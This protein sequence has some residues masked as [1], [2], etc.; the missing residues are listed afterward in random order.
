M[1][2]RIKIAAIL[3]AALLAVGCT[4]PV[5]A[6]TG[7]GDTSCQAQLDAALA[8]KTSLQTQVAQYQQDVFLCNVSLKVCRGNMTK[9]NILTRGQCNES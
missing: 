1:D 5:A 9:C 6:S 8:E 7:A 3:L 4:Q 2:N